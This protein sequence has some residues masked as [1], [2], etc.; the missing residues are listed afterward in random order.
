MTSTPK[1]GI[2]FS[3][4]RLLSSRVSNVIKGDLQEGENATTEESIVNEEVGQKPGETREK[5]D[6]DKKVSEEDLRKGAEDEGI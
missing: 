6:S 3:K 2:D 5:I 1:T 4:L